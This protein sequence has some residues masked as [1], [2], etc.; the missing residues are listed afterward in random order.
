[1]HV[2]YLDLSSAGVSAAPCLPTG[3][4]AQ[5]F[6]PRFFFFNRKIISLLP[7]SSSFVLGEKR[8]RALEAFRLVIGRSVCHPAPGTLAALIR[9][10]GSL[11]SWMLPQNTDQ[12][13]A[14]LLW[15][16][17]ACRGGGRGG[18]AVRC[19]DKTKKKAYGLCAQPQRPAFY[20]RL[21]PFLLFSAAP[22]L[23]AP[24]QQVQSLCVALR[25]VSLK[26]GRRVSGWVGTAGPSL[27]NLISP[28]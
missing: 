22:P 15:T 6:F 12:M 7:P 3:A 1:M 14:A 9:S 17:S 24:G 16:A 10:P 11:T 2:N 28:G 26:S 5:F 21:L 20:I 27:V 13:T 8:W 19:K 23:C 4:A 18:L 25:L